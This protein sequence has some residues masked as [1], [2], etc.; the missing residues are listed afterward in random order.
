MKTYSEAKEL[1]ASYR[2]VGTDCVFVK[3][4]G[5]AWAEATEVSMST[6]SGDDMARLAVRIAE[7]IAQGMLGLDLEGQR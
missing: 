2:E 1:A 6:G 4:D 3:P 5:A 7:A